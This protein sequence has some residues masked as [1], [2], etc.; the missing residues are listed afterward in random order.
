[1]PVVPWT[2]NTSPSWDGVFTIKGV[3]ST[4]SEILRE[5]DVKYMSNTDTSWILEA[6]DRGNFIDGTSYVVAAESLQVV[7]NQ[8]Y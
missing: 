8:S 5:V 6:N 2:T 1:M 3:I 7:S 4:Q